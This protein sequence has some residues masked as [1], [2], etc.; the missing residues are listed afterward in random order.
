MISTASQLAGDCHAKNILTTLISLKQKEK[1]C[2]Y[3]NADIL[4]GTFELKRT[5]KHVQSATGGQAP[6]N[7]NRVKTNGK[8]GSVVVLLFEVSA[9]TG[10]FGMGK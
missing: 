5:M 3:C 10:F 2:N 4:V 8:R 1:N 7:V 6:G 9:Y